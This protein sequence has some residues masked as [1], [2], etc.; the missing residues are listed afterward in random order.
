[1][2]VLLLD[3]IV[4]LPCTILHYCA[5]AASKLRATI[6]IVSDTAFKDPSTDEVGI[7]LENVFTNQ[8]NTWDVKYTLIIPDDINAIQQHISQ[9]CD[10]EAD[11]II[12]TGGTGFAV[13][14]RTPEA[15]KPMI[16]REAPGLV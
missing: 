12:T 14:D 6:L 9:C 3:S 7:K 5:M 15:V 16:D 13:K 2:L 10:D 1:M 4:L 8:G 11:Y